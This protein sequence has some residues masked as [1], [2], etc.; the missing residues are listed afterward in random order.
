MR[1]HKSLGTRLSECMLVGRN[2]VKL[3]LVGRG[4]KSKFGVNPSFFISKSVHNEI[5]FD[6]CAFGD[7]VR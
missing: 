4:L 1:T 5:P 3:N 6:A 7:H 2:S